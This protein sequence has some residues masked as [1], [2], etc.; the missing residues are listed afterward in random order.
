M[1]RGIPIVAMVAMSAVADCSSAQD[2]QIEHGRDLYD[3]MCTVCHGKDG[4]GY[5]ADRAPA[6]GHQEFLAAASDAFLVRAL[7]RGR[8]GTTMSAWGTTRGGPLTP[9]DERAIV[10]F[11]RTWQKTPSVAL[12]ERPLA[13]DAT[14]GMTIYAR[15]CNV[16]HGDKGVHGWFESIANPELIASASNGF[17]RYA[18]GHGRSGMAMSA[19]TPLIGDAAIDDV[20]AALRT[21]APAPVDTGPPPP[22][23]LGQVV[24]NPNGPEPAAFQTFPAYTPADT[25]KAQLDLGARFGILDARAPTDYSIEHIAGAVSVPFYDPNPFLPQLPKN[26]WLVCYCACPHAESGALAQKLLDAGFSKVAVL[27]EGFPAWK[28]RGYPTH[29]GSSP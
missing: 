24:L 12:D 4:E 11:M 23:S 10:A 19:Y 14:G 5:V 25:I 18:I 26:A 13:G 9:S 1:K 17:L 21:W 20:I 16:C 7:E 6:I 3:R 15:E 2:T 27:D 8:P 29:T 28:S 22:P